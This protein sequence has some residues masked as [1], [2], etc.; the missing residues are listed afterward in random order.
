MEAVWGVWRKK[1]TT[2]K[3]GICDT[4]Y[5]STVAPPKAEGRQAAAG[6]GSVGGGQNMTRT[7]KSGFGA[8]IWI[9]ERMQLAISVTERR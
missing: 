5:R 8:D 1:I 7:F 4:V 2:R 3:T 6:D 9:L